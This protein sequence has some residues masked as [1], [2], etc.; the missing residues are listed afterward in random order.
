MAI[1][2]LARRPAETP[3]IRKT[4]EPR[5]QLACRWHKDETGRLV[6]TWHDE[7]RPE[8]E[9]RP[10]GRVLPFVRKRKGPRHDGL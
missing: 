2:A 10:R 5:T 3:D 9:P 6:C 8:T 4:L 1:E 7:A